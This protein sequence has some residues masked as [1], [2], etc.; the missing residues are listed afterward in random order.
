MTVLGFL[1]LLVVTVGWITLPLLP[2]LREL[3]RPTDV[4]PLGMVGR[5]NADT[6]RFARHFREYVEAH[7]HAALPAGSEVQSLPDGTALVRLPPTDDLLPLRTLPAAAADAVVVLDAPAELEG[8]E[9]FRKEIWAREEFAGGP[10]ASYRA[11]LG[12]RSL[13]LGPRSIVLRW[14]HGAGAVTVGDE[15]HLYGRTSSDRQIRLG[16]QV[17]FDRLGAPAIVVRNGA[18]R[19]MPPTP[20]GLLRLETPKRSRQLG[21]HLRVESDLD[22]PERTLVEGHLV[23][24]GRLRLGRGSRVRGNVKAHG[25]I[26]VAPEVVVDGSIVS[27]RAISLGTDGWVRGPVISEA[28]IRVGSRT[29]VGAPAH[30]TTVS[31]RTVSLAPDSAVCGLIVTAEGGQ[32]E[33]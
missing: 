13:G 29:T 7:L 14:L 3:L 25:E 8:G 30:L 15:S 2:A 33:R 21:D 11:A 23:V 6:S 4:E 12:E 5:D 28:D 22:V 1:G 27:R 16:A 18:A 17:G 26:E 31:G 20:D 19:A 10:G 24:A 9:V 32:T